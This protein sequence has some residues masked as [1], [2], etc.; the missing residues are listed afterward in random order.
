[1]E[2]A[3]S[4]S[5]IYCNF[6]QLLATF[7]MSQGGAPSCHHGNKPPDSIKGEQFVD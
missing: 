5:F 3:I 7:Q 1:M 2:L 6:I 4:A